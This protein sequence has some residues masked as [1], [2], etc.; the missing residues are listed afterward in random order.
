M[1]G[2]HEGHVPLVLFA[3]AISTWHDH[4]PVIVASVFII[5]VL[6]QILVWMRY[7]WREPYANDIDSLSEKLRPL[8]V[9]Q[10]KHFESVPHD[11]SSSA[12]RK[13]FRN[14]PRKI[15][16]RK[17]LSS[18]RQTSGTKRLE[19][20][21][22]IF[23]SSLTGSTE[24]LAADLASTFVANFSRYP[25]EC[26][27]KVLPPESIDLSNVDLD[28]YFNSAPK[29]SKSTSFFY[30]LLVPSYDIDTNLNNF[31]DHLK[32]THNDFRVDTA[33]L[34][35]LVGYSV[36]GFGDREGWPTEEEGFC[37]QAKEADKWLA[38]LTGR[39][40]AYPL[41]M[42]DVKGDADGR[43][44]EWTE[45]LEG[46]LRDLAEGKSLGEGVPGSGD[47]VESEEE[48]EG[49]EDQE[50]TAEDV[51]RPKLQKFN[52]KT[53]S[54][55]DDLENLG[56]GFRGTLKQDEAIAIDFTTSKSGVLAPG[57]RKQ[58]VPESSPTHA[59]LTKQGYTI[60]GSHSGVKI[61]RWTKSAL[62]GRG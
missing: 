41:G 1:D 17:P 54:S 24:K 58:M 32:E 15:Q 5:A 44:R 48:G 34:S 39:K 51:E 9:A 38:K 45:G 3:D 30:V 31:L 12:G 36:F 61:C 2:V 13:V 56:K 53:N 50:S 57:Q 10:E 11:V 60:V 47:A 16:G 35:N 46:L 25:A 52:K 42:G 37:C 43:L 40:R 59:S 55:L 49:E 8:R 28:Y 29:A 19:I 21:P 26:S 23:W 22:V 6:T 27:S 33:P 7:R 20:Q 62:R 4:R 14:L 18:N